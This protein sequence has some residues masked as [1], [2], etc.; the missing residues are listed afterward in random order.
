MATWKPGAHKRLLTSFAAVKQA[1]AAGELT[2][3][4]SSLV[5]N[6]PLVP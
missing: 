3:H 5:V 4:K 6:C 1:Q 2:L